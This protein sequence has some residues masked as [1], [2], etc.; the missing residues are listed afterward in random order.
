MKPYSPA[1][2]RNRAPILE[3]LRRYFTSG[4]DVL[5]IGAG[6]GQHA[7]YFAQCLPHLHW[8]ATDIEP[9]LSAM[10]SRIEEAALGNLTGPLELDVLASEWPVRRADHIFSANTAHIMSWAAVTAMFRG[11]GRV[12]APGGFFVLYGPF[13]RSGA[14]TSESNRLFD[15]ALRAQDAAMGL[16]DDR[17]LIELALGCGLVLEADVDMPAN[18]RILVWRHA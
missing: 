11:V 17:E 7:E 2:E 14:H 9:S 6:T 3:V 1:S 12:L 15:E 4:S 8:L 16:R 18:N 5:E 10:R 13:N